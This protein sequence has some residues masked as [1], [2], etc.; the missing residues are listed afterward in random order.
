MADTVRRSLESYSSRSDL[1]RRA[2]TSCKIKLTIPKRFD[3]HWKA[4]SN[5]NWTKCRFSKSEEFNIQKQADLVY[6]H[7][8][9]ISHHPSLSNLEV[10]RQPI[11]RAASSVAL[12]HILRLT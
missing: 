11:A 10:E 12:G 6:N 3:N 9:Y 5:M 4:S 7:S 1:S 8:S 2:R